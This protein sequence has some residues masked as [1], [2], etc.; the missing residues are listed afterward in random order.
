MIKSVIWNGVPCVPAMFIVPTVGATF[1]NRS[2]SVTGNG[3]CVAISEGTPPSP[4]R[5]SMNS[6][7][8]LGGMA[9][10]PFLG[11]DLERGQVPNEP[12]IHL[13]YFPY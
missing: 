13:I 4:R 1:W 6:W 10:M 12:V 11:N 7:K 2:L 3:T 5:K 8:P 9:K